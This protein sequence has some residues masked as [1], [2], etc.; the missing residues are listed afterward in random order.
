MRKYLFLLMSLALLLCACNGQKPEE[1]D[2]T[3]PPETKPVEFY[4]PGSSVE[5]DTNG[6]VRRYD[7]HEDCLEIFNADGRLLILTE[8]GIRLMD[9][10][11]GTVIAALEIDAVQIE[12]LQVLKN[13]FSYYD[14]QNH[15]V[16]YLDGALN[17]TANE[18]LTVDMESPLVSPDGKSIYY[19]QGNDIRVYEPE[20]KIS[21]LLKTHTCEKQ[22]LTGIYFDGKILECEITV[23]AGITK[24]IYILTE[25]GKTV[26]DGTNVLHMYTH[27][28]R[29]L[30]ERVDGIVR[31]W[32]VGERDGAVNLLDTDD[33][34]M[35]D[36]LA[37]DG[38]MGC[39][40][41]DDGVLLKFYNVVSG[42]KTA[43]ILLKNFEEPE[44]VVAD[45][46]KGVLWLQMDGTQLLRWDVEEQPTEGES[47][48]AKLY[49]ADSPDKAGLKK[50]NERVSLL[51]NKYGVRIRI[52]E[53]AVKVTE[54]HNLE[55][56]YQTDAI[57]LML[58]E[59]EAVFKE[60]PRKFIYKSISSR[61]RI[62]IVRSV[63]GEIKGTQFWSDKYAFIVLSTGVDIRSEFL[64]AFGFV[65]D[66]HILG[67][68]P[69]FDYW[70][71][72]NPE[73][74]VYG[75]ALNGAPVTG[76]KRAF[77]DA[78]S[79]E[80]ATIDRSRVF[81]QA[82]QPD[83]SAMFQ[84]ETMQNKLNMLCRGIRDAWRLE[85]E[86]DIYPWEQYLAEPIAAK[87]K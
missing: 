6:E 80:S 39:S 3:P 75:S 34:R 22:K 63:D 69:V 28:Q 52:W 41:Q 15:S 21:R 74:F 46:Q 44:I 70:N 45:P 27:D 35:Y 57:S 8:H 19:C 87:K 36:A 2:P 50:L 13:G 47:V 29:Y 12:N 42:K 49:T 48:F 25:N 11:A 62:C 31:H 59:L 54:D 61:V 84:S 1:N 33:E 58:D 17:E 64:K 53:E 86:T 68:S 9:G 18:I 66:S 83:S 82:M 71:G 65:V 79:M 38:V 16:R 4:V 23:S 72:L 7:V 14:A 56:E 77:V 37:M 24:I 73:G 40:V 60:F 20:R 85:K 78:E 10:D 43:S 32:A 76:E 51:N 67:N 26:F 55:V 30:M 5:N 81:W